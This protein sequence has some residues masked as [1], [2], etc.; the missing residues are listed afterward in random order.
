MS[1]RDLRSSVDSKRHQAVADIREGPQVECELREG[2]QVECGLGIG[3]EAFSLDPQW[4]SWY[5]E[6]VVRLSRS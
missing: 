1:E 5:V 4:A 6:F 3:P 2:P